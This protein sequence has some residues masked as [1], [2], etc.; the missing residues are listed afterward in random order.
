[1]EPKRFRKI[2]EHLGVTSKE[3]AGIVHSLALEELKKRNGELLKEVPRKTR[4]YE[5]KKMGLWNIDLAGIGEA[6]V[7]LDEMHG[8]RFLFVSSFNVG[9]PINK[10]SGLRKQK[11]GSIL[12]NIIKGLAKR[13]KKEAI[14]LVCNGRVKEFYEKNGFVR[15]KSA[16]SD[17]DGTESH[18]MIFFLNPKLKDWFEKDPQGLIDEIII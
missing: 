17:S 3:R 13:E 15:F 5:N 12:L 11:L 14:L 7:E 18:V 2:Q 1:M 16:G 6:M 10:D 4:V 8:E 9:D